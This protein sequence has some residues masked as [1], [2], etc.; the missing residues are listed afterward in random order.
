MIAQADTVDIR[1]QLV[2]RVD[3]VLEQFLIITENQVGLHL[4]CIIEKR[5]FGKV[6][7]CG[8]FSSVGSNG[9]DVPYNYFDMQFTCYAKQAC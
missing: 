6:P 4:V 1:R 2:T 5:V 8:M 9:K 7:V 3:K